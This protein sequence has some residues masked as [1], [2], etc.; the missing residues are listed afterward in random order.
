MILPA[1]FMALSFAS[2]SCD[3]SKVGYWKNP[4]GTRGGSVAST[5][6]VSAGV[7]IGPEAQVCGEAVVS[8]KTHIFGRAKITGKTKIHNATICQAS[9]ISG[10]DVVD[11]DYYCQTEDPEPRHPGEAG[12]KTLLGIDSDN[13]GVRDDVE[14]WINEKF[15]NTPDRDMFNYRMAFKQFASAKLNALKFKEDKAKVMESNSLGFDA[16]DCLR[17]IYVSKKGD[18]KKQYQQNLELNDLREDFE[19]A[20]YNT[21]ERIKA[22]NMTRKHSHGEILR[23]AKK[24]FNGCHFNAKGN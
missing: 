22:E 6:K 10:F 19:V 8:G 24:T 3:G 9:Q 2:S 20:F 17:T 18:Y 7:I 14:I 21:K 23:S 15:S 4:D 16:F 5:A 13:D 11:S 12:K 1:L